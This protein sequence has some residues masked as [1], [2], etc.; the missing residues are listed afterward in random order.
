MPCEESIADAKATFVSAVSEGI[1]VLMNRCGYSRERATSALLRELNRG[2]TT[3]P[4]DEEVS[5]EREE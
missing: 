4:N 5:L 2:E 1:D 3:R